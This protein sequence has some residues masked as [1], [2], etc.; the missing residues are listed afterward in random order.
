MGIH[1]DIDGCSHDFVTKQ[2]FDL[3]SQSLSLGSVAIKGKVVISPTVV[4]IFVDLR[5]L[6]EEGCHSSLE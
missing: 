1:F 5:S 6:F 2:E 4:A 3:H